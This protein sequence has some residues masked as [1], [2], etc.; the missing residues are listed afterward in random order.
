M[1]WKKATPN[2]IIV[3]LLTTMVAVGA[4]ITKTQYLNYDA[5]M[6][7]EVEITHIKIMFVEGGDIYTHYEIDN[8]EKIIELFSHINEIPVKRTF[9]K[10]TDDI[11]VPQT[12]F[13]NID[14]YYNDINIGWIMLYDEYI[15]RHEDLKLFK[16]KEN[17]ESIGKE[18]KNIIEGW[19]E[20]K[21]EAC[22]T[23]GDASASGNAKWMTFIS[24]VSWM[25]AM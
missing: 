19:G 23:K 5:T 10:K 21:G 9:F 16:L 13:C 14:L 18:I 6:Y 11:D 2:I 15:Y 4:W 20:T 8:K 24:N 22:G 3:L 17:K 7:G 12:C 25:G 1:S